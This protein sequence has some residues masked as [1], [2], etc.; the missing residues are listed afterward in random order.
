ML[1]LPEDP[2]FFTKKKHTPPS[3]K[4]KTK[5]TMPDRMACRKH[6]LYLEPYLLSCHSNWNI[7]F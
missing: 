6:K 3:Q 5:K 1:N 2:E 4:T 7:M